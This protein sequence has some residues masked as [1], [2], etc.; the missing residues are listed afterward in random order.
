LVESQPVAFDLIVAR[1][2]LLLSHCGL[3]FVSSALM[4]GLPQILAPYDIEKRLIAAS[5]EAMGLGRRR[6]FESLDAAAFAQFL[7]EAFAD[8]ALSRRARAAAPG[9]RSRM[10]D[11]DGPDAARAIEELL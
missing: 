10:G 1:S 9:F 5:V 6:T 7:R 2:R 11:A 4:A 8:D 3:G